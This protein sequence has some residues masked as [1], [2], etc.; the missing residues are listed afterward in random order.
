[1][2]A[3]RLLPGAA[4]AIAAALP[5]CANPYAYAPDP[6]AF[7]PPLPFAPPAEEPLPPIVFQPNPRPLPPLPAAPEDDVRPLPPPVA[8]EVPPA[9]APEAP[10]PVQEVPP[11]PIPAAATPPDPEKGN[12]PLMGFRPMRGQKAPGA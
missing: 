12:V 1:M 10:T 2:R 7:R 11:A 9:A 5:G 4:L 8:A 6:V 3:C